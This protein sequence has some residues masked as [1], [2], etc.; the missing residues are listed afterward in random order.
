ML[1]PNLP[2]GVAARILPVRAVGVPSAFQSK[3]AFCFVEKK[4]GAIAFTLIPTLLKWTA[5]HCVK[6]EIAALAPE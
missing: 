2:I 1:S 6:L 3:A 4:P 5:S